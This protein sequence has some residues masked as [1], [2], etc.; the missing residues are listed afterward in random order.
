MNLFLNEPVSCQRNRRLYIYIGYFQ[1]FTFLLILSTF[2]LIFIRF[3]YS[4][5]GSIGLSELIAYCAG[6]CLSYLIYAYLSKKIRSKNQTSKTLSILQI[7]FGLQSLIFIII[8]LV[9][10]SE[11]SINQMKSIAFSNWRMDIQMLDFEVE[12][13][14]S[15]LHSH[16]DPCSNCCD[17]KFASSISSHI[18]TNRILLF[19]SCVFLIIDMLI[20]PA[21][22]LYLR[23]KS[24]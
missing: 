2:L 9:L 7:L 13:K 11:S 1:I 22:E 23:C 6:S 21:R 5:Y 10:T 8:S 18:S 15:G 20:S 12:N 19:I 3:Y 14:C 17:D 16:N 24:T 4:H